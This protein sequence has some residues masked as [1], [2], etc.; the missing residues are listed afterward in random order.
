MKVSGPL[1]SEQASGTIAGV[2]TFSKRQSGQQARFQKKQKDRQSVDQLAQRFL[3]LNAADAC[4]FTELGEAICGV[5]M[6]GCNKPDNDEKAKGKKYTGYNL[7][8]ADY[9]DAY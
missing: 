8:I 3:F 5:A 6:C 7:C 2:L 9:L 1:Q 4:R